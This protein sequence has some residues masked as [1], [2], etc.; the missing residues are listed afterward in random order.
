M[1]THDHPRMSTPPEADSDSVNGQLAEFLCSR[2]EEMI[3]SWIG[4]IQADPAIPAESLTTNQLRDNLPRLFDDL[5]DTILRYGSDEV[6]NRTARDA[7]KH[8]AERWQQG[9][10]LPQLLR[11]IMHLRGIFIYHLR[12]FEEQHAGF[13]TASRLYAH[14]TVHQF[15]DELTIDATVQFLTSDRH[16]RRARSGIAQ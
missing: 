4:R 10:E 12:I 3:R 7:E 6:A 2:K 15:L 1:R 8:G 9:F 14:S 13:G 5:A 11:E 16:A